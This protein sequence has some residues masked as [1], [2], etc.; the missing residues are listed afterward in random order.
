MSV[1]A[2]GLLLG[3]CGARKVRMMASSARRHG[4]VAGAPGTGKAATLQVLA[5]AFSDIGVPV[6]ATDTSGELAGMSQ[7]G[8]GDAA[9]DRRAKKLRLGAN[10]AREGY[11]VVL[12][13]ALG[14][15]GSGG[16]QGHPLRTTVSALG[17]LLLS[18]M[19]G[20]NDTQEAV[21]TVVY[22]V[23]D[24]MGL[25]LLDTKDLRAMLKY[26]AE[27]AA[28]ISTEYGSV[29]AASVGTIQ[30]TLLQFEERGGVRLLGEPAIDV[31]DLVAG[32][33]GG[34]GGALGGGETGGGGRGVVN[35]LVAERLVTSRRTYSALLLWLL[36]ELSARLPEVG[37]GAGRAPALVV[38][39]DDAEVLFEDAPA[40]LIDTVEQ[41]LRSL[42]ARGVGVFFAT[43]NPVDLPERVL[44]H[45][46][47]KVQHA[48]RDYT[49]RDERRVV[50]AAELL[51]SNP[52]FLTELVLTAM[53]PGEAL[54]SVI[55]EDGTPSRVE[56]V[57]M[58]P[59]HAHMGTLGEDA[60]RALCAASPMAG[61][62]EVTVDRESAYEVL[63]VRLEATAAE[64]A[65]AASA[66]AEAKA[67]LQQARLEAA[68]ARAVAAAER[69]TRASQG[70][71]DAMLDAAGKSAARSIG[72]QV[73]RTIIRGILGAA[74]KTGVTG[75]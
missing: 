5:E 43:E 64:R 70:R 6:F 44:C 69:A 23:A 42:S 75:N 35:L 66:A 8:G 29:S 63:K 59:P 16:G 56:R 17:P 25:L 72:N 9:M 55:G 39:I 14:G 48:L 18:R 46:G 37:G 53:E 68:Q 1:V 62:Y 52:A 36:G 31:M 67:A 54:V 7:P 26:C 74:L 10:W 4:Y 40:W 12:W 11:P 58:V 41:L 24:E 73:G 51:R 19:L 38:L 13:D 30:R 2:E 71:G 50:A 20:L 27:H 34:G 28:E 47:T 57:V 60:R 33:G 21:L 61:R 49:P 32:A 22:R 15:G 65:A 3:M 45:L